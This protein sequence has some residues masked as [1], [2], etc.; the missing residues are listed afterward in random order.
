MRG[1]SPLHVR[2]WGGKLEEAQQ[3]FYQVTITRMSRL[4]ARNLSI[5]YCLY[6]TVFVLLFSPC[7]VGDWTKNPEQ[8][9]A[10]HATWL[11]SLGT[12]RGCGLGQEKLA[13]LFLACLL[14][15]TRASVG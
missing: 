12:G 14:L 13:L 9:H 4:L 1:S 6:R 3:K 8:K 11:G 5:L 2:I 7:P 15:R 10:R